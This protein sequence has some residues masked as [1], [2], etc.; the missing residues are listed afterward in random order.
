MEMMV[1]VVFDGRG[2][3]VEVVFDGNDGGIVSYDGGWWCLIVEV[4]GA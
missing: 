1:T 4:G 2:E 3:V